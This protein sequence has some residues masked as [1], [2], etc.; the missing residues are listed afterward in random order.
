MIRIE[1]GS[2]REGDCDHKT[3]FIWEQLTPF[4]GIESVF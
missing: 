3:A 1:E 2:K 4:N